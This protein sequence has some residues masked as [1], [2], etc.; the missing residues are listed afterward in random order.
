MKTKKI[1]KFIDASYQKNAPE[2]INRFKLDK[3][4]SSDVAK[5]YNKD[6]KAVIVHRGTQGAR[7][8]K[9]NLAYVLG[10]YKSTDRFKEAKNIQNKAIDKYGASNIS[11]IGHSQGGLLAHELGGKTKEIITVNPASLGEKRKANE[12]TIRSSGDIVS[13]LSRPDNKDIVIPAKNRFDVLGEHST[14]IL[15]RVPNQNIGVSRDFRTV[16]GI[17]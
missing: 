17:R 4:L 16:Q 1:K 14:N 5:V 11:T 9:N 13:A 15:D 12:Y 8:W 3:E 6:H 2:N 7:D 10:K